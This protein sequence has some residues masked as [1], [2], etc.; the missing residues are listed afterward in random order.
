MILIAGG[1]GRLGS[2]V[3]ERLRR[4]GMPV[5]VLTRNPERTASLRSLGIEVVR[6]DIRKVSEVDTA[7][8][9]V[10]LVVSAVQGFAGVGRESPA[11]VDRDGNRNLIDAA[12][13]IGAGVV[14]MSVVGA[15]ADSALEL[16]RMKHAAERHLMARSQS[17]TILRSAA[18]TELW[19]DLL[20]QTAARGGAP[21]VFGRGAVPVEFVSV[22]DVAAA[23]ETAVLD[24]SLRGSAV[25]IA[26]PDR[27]SFTRLAEA[28]Q[29]AAGRSA[30]PRHVP[31]AVLKSM[32]VLARPIKPELARQARGALVMDR[33]PLPVADPAFRLAHP[34]IPVTSVAEV[35]SAR[36]AA[37]RT[38]VR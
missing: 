4:R 6:G 13:R 10:D 25:E 7:V 20:E 22:T 33:T 23:V 34:E 29:D 37:Q 38:R 27:W 1:T 16:F 8:A 18:F 30:S 21:L 9:G 14:M 24:E 2:L 32:A 31:S 5:R 19:I 3:V 12:A 36:F 11:S 15:S 26:G 35:L 28:V 17:W